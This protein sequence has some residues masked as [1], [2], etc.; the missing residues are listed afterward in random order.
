VSYNPAIPRDV[1]VKI[2]RIAGQDAQIKAFQKYISTNSRDISAKEKNGRRTTISVR[3]VKSMNRNL[4]KIELEHLSEKDRGKLH[5]ELNSCRQK[6]ANLL[7]L[8]E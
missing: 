7:E 4:E 5:L 3:S 6:I 2:S 1:L 8:L